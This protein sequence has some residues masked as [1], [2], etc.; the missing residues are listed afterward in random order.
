MSPRR[1]RQANE[2]R[3]LVKEILRLPVDLRDVFLLHRM[4]GLSYEQI[5][6]HLN[7]GR[8]VVEA[9]LAEALVLLVA[10]QAPRP[11]SAG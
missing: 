7:V 10:V 4:A 6:E 11:R 2:K 5:G 1:G 8:D 9:R 3:V